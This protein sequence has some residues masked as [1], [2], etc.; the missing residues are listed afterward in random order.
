[1]SFVFQIF[2]PFLVIGGHFGMHAVNGVWSLQGVRK[3]KRNLSRD[4]LGTRYMSTGV[5]GS[6]KFETITCVI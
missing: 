5:R 4:I 3:K 1:M 6:I 2:T